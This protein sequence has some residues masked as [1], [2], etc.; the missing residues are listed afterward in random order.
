VVHP[1]GTVSSRQNVTLIVPP[2][3]SLV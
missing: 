1:F 2:G 3:V